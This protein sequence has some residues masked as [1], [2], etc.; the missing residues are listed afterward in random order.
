[1]EVISSCHLLLQ[2]GCSSF[3]FEWSHNVDIRVISL[4]DIS[5]LEILGYFFKLSNVAGPIEALS[6]WVRRPSLVYY[7]KFRLF[8]FDFW[9]LNRRLFLDLRYFFLRFRLWSWG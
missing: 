2:L 9:L 3:A 8:L 1:M 7:R 5:K 4:V 6:A